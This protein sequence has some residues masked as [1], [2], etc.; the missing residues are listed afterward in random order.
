MSTDDT[1]QAHPTPNDFARRLLRNDPNTDDQRLSLPP[2]EA[3][4]AGGA[5]R[6]DQADKAAGGDEEERFDA[7]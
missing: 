2:D 7:G 1:A 4:R 5:D 6:S 3:D